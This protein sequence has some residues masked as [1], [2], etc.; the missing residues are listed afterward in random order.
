MII[1]ENKIARQIGESRHAYQV[2]WIYVSSMYGTPRK[3]QVS[4]IWNVWIH[5]RLHAREAQPPFA[6]SC[7]NVS[8]VKSSRNR[9]HFEMAHVR[10]DVTTGSDAWVGI[11]SRECKIRNPFAHVYIYIYIYGKLYFRSYNSWK[12]NSS[13]FNISTFFSYTRIF[14]T[15]RLWISRRC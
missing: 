12:L 3:V 7:I 15:P 1:R 4:C 5:G 9:S 6:Y 2:R 14:G 13:G 10:G 8:Y 11:I